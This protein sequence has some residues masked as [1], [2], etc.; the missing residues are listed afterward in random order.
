VLLIAQRTDMSAPSP[1]TDLTPGVV[2]FLAAV[3]GLPAA[4]AYWATVRALPSRLMRRP[5]LRTGTASGA[6]SQGS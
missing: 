1:S 4:V 2:V 6:T 3:T 5:G